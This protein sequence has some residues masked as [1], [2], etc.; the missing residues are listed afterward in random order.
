MDILKKLEEKVEKKVIKKSEEYF[1][2]NRV[3]IDVDYFCNDIG[4]TE[5]INE[6]IKFKKWNKTE[7]ECVYGIVRGTREYSTLI[8][9]QDGD[10]VAGDCNCMDFYETQNICKHMVAMALEHEYRIK[11]HTQS[12]KKSS[13]LDFFKVDYSDRAIPLKIDVDLAVRVI[14]YG[15][16]KM[17]EYYFEIVTPNKRYKLDN[18]L[19]KFLVA[20]KNKKPFVFGK[21]YT[22]NPETDYFIESSR[23]LLEYMYEHMLIKNMYIV[24][25]STYE[26]HIILEREFQKKILDY[27][28]EN[29]KI[30]I[31]EK[32][33]KDILELNISE[34]DEKLIFYFKGINSLEVIVEK[35]ITS[36]QEFNKVFYKLSEEEIELFKKIKKTVREEKLTFDNENLSE[37]INKA[38]EIGKVKF[39]KTIEKYIYN[40]EKSELKI[41]VDSYKEFGLKVY[42]KIFYNGKS[43]DELSQAIYKKDLDIKSL[44]D[45]VL[46]NY[47]DNY[48]E[49]SYYIESIENVYNFIM[50]GIPKLEEKYEIYYSEKFKERK[51]SIASYN[52]RTK[53]TD[54]LEINFS[55]DGIEKKEIKEF[56]NAVKEK[57]RYF[58]LKNGGILKID[59]SQDLEKLN[60]ML[61]ITEASIKEIENGLISREKNYMYFLK[62]TLEKIKNVAL[63]EEFIKMKFNLKNIV[64]S[65]EKKEIKDEFPILRDYQIEGVKWLKTIQKL[66]L[67]GILADDMGL[68][69]TLQTIAYLSLE[70][71]E[72]PSIVI[73][74]KSLA[75]N[76]KNEFEK[77]APNI[78]VKMC[79]GKKDERKKVISE[80]KKGEILITTYGILKND[81]DL[82]E[83][84]FA[85]IVIDEAQNI[86]NILGK[87]SN[88]I[89]SLKGE[90]KIALT[91]TPIEN[92]ILELWNIFD[93]TF[94]GYLGGHTSFKNRFVDNLKDLREVISPF[95]LRRTKKEVLK[96]LPE[97]IEKNIVIELEDKQKKLYL[98]YLDKYRE[99]IEKNKSDTIKILSFITRLRQLCNHP[100]LFLEDYKG[101]SSKVDVLIELL[102]KAKKNGHRVLLF[103]QFTEMLDIIKKELKEKFE[104]LY[105]DGKTSAKNRI[106]LVEKFNKGEGDIFVI[107]LKAGGSGLNLT[108][109]D[110]VIHFDP[111]W[112]PS[113]ENQAT[114]RAHR[115][116]QKNSVTVYRLIT[117]GTIE[118]KINL[119]KAEKTKIISEVL[120]GEKKNL[121]SLNREELLKLF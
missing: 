24:S 83:K 73:T 16:T 95:I 5:L 36:F 10:I 52:I 69:K 56:L 110:T 82:Y 35:Y 32:K 1:R 103:S 120:D 118:E 43:E 85:N 53:I 31:Q 19:E 66:G 72:K 100:K 92:N 115:I 27:L 116:G 68:G 30:I 65:E 84:D 23:K 88:I 60:D 50:E 20:Y 90:T 12:S 80:L 97:K 46:E 13:A 63:D 49:K 59:E 15:N 87:T 61:D 11:K 121:L 54:M 51:Y 109:A 4:E 74:P 28:N 6:C 77:F 114:D 26:G 119:I 104:I 62:S 33:L 64:T 39:D 67:S 79:V 41:Y 112:N 34:K 99:E 42:S 48:V 94:P 96:E 91:G 17:I 111:W 38:F 25:Y 98:G 21:N 9:L 102:E 2:E 75:Y 108:G 58:L 47:K 57:N 113:V 45:S 93:F 107:S 37:V 40:Y 117:R 81:I 18:K 106:D 86:K 70:K 29:K 3:E 8:F 89:K 105:L 55:I 101:G 44:F 71:R 76:W 7:G 22:Y 78:S 14:Y